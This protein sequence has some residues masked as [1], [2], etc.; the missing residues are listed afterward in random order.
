MAKIRNSE[1]DAFLVDANGDFFD[2]SNA[3]NDGDIAPSVTRAANEGFGD[4][5]E[6]IADFFPELDLETGIFTFEED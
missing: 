3:E 6:V 5:D 4:V 2:S 1:G